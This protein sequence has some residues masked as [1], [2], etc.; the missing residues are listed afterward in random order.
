MRFRH[1]TN[2]ADH[3]PT[4]LGLTLS[5][6]SRMKLTILVA[7]LGYFVDLFDLILFVLVRSPSL[8]DLHVPSRELLSTGALL[9]NMQMA[10]L[11]IGGVFWGVLGDRRGRLSVLLGSI[12]LY[13]VANI[14]NAAA[15]SVT[16]YAIW[17]FVAGLGL[18]GELGAGVTIV[19]E[20]LPARS[21][22]AWHAG[23]TT[24]NRHTSRTL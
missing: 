8:K 5:P 15:D 3:Q 23:W 4:P 14:A 10:G 16:S 1:H 18:A 22:R 21:A 7:T 12:V 11:L 6:R 20:L 19:S 9:L 13:S 2:F 17:R 24:T